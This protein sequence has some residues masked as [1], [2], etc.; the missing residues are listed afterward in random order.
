MRYY[1]GIGSRNTPDSIL[2]AFYEIGFRLGHDFV[3]RSGRA[4]GADSYFEKGAVDAGGRCE[5]FLPWRDFQKNSALATCPAYVFDSLCKQQRDAALAS[6][7]RYHPNPNALTSGAKKL[8]ARNYCQLFG[9]APDSE[10]SAFVICYTSDGLASGGTGQAM[11]MAEEAGIPVFN[12]HG[13]EDHPEQFIAQIIQHV[14]E[15]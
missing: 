8:M 4:D 7:N 2:R 3:L 13:Y 5:I 6:V 1:T 12:A 15:R 9:V 11:R 14:S 10:K